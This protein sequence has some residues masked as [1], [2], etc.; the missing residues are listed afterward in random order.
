MEFVNFVDFMSGELFILK[1]LST[2]AKIPL[3]HY[4]VQWRKILTSE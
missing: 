1:N 4:T 2:F 3:K